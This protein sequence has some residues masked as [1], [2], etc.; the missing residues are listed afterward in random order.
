M[1]VKYYSI[2]PDTIHGT[3]MFIV[4][5][6]LIFDGKCTVNIPVPWMVWVFFW[7]GKR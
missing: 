4:H 3:G 6:W 7:V 5:E 2:W 1:L